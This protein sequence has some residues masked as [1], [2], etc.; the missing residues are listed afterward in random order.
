MW[1]MRVRECARVRHVTVDYD[2]DLFYFFYIIGFVV[3]TIDDDDDGGGDGDDG[4]DGDHD[5]AYDGT[6]LIRYRKF[7][8]PS[9]VS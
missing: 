9:T 6:V 3:V 7:V 5:D 8:S 4:D 2:T 1:R